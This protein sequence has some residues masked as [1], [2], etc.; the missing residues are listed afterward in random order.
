MRKSDRSLT[1]NG[2]SREARHCSAW[3]AVPRREVPRC[4]GA[5]EMNFSP[6]DSFPLPKSSVPATVSRVKLQNLREETGKINVGQLHTA[7]ERLSLF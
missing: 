5:Q 7:I 1:A 3:V 2:L 4:K 6:E